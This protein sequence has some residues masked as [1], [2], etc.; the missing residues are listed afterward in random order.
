MDAK[1]N[2]VLV[3]IQEFLEEDALHSLEEAV[4]H[5]AGVISV[6]HNPEQSHM[7]M[8]VYDSEST[9]ASSL[10]HRFQERACMR[11]SSACNNPIRPGGRRALS[12]AASLR[13]PRQASGAFDLSQNR[14]ETGPCSAIP[15][16]RG[17]P[18]SNPP[19]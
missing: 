10:L 9:R 19:A 17:Q 1:L 7:I 6:G 2:D 13:L 8:V 18:R 15:K 16:G 14:P 11:R 12:H 3:H 5:E 4:R